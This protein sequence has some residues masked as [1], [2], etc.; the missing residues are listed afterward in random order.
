MRSIWFGANILLRIWIAERGGFVDAL[1]IFMASAQGDY[2]FVGDEVFE[3]WDASVSCPAGVCESGMRGDRRDGGL[4][5][6][7]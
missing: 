6:F 7:G 1:D 2:G 3:V 5:V 4:P